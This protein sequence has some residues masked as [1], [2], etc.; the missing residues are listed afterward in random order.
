MSAL[1]IFALICGIFGIIG[2][3]APALPGPPVSWLGLLLLYLGHESEMSLNFLIVFLVITI[4]VTVLDYVVP[5]WT[6]KATGGH[7]AASVGAILGLFAGIFL[8]PLGMI[9]GSLLGAFVGELMV[10]DNGAWPAFK[11]A[12]GAFIGFIFGTVMKLAV[13]GVML[14]YIIRFL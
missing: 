3:I 5:A 12:I 6:T 1:E 9:A 14:Y 13:S 11:A 7:K 2:S 4:V 10:T 8:S